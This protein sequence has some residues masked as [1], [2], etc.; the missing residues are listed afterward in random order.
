MMQW[1]GKSSAGPFWNCKEEDSNITLRESLRKRRN[2]NY[3][4]LK[5]Y[6]KD[7]KKLGPILY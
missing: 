3:T 4:S 1:M 6:D 5:Q 2:P 7:N